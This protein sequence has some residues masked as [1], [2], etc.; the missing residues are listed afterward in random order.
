VV[1]RR[2]FAQ[3]KG[4]GGTKLV[5]KGEGGKVGRGGAEGVSGLKLL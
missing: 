4:V 1:G 3:G 2:D 5:D